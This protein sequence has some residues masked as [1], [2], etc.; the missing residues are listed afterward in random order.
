MPKDKTGG[1][2]TPASPE[3]AERSCIFPMQSQGEDSHPRRFTH[4]HR[5]A[6]VGH[7]ENTG[8]PDSH[9]PI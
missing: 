7:D 3:T 1:A 9:L 6:R 8:A 5:I 2:K 4:P